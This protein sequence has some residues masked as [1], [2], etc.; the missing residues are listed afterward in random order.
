[1]ITVVINAAIAAIAIPNYTDYVT[2][3]KFAEA[4]GHLADQRVK[5]EQYYMD[6]RRY[7]SD[8]GGATSGPGNT[9]THTNPTSFDYTCATSNANTVGAQ[10]Y[11]I[12]A[13]GKAAE[14][15]QGISFTVNQA[16]T[17]TTTVAGGSAMATKG[18]ATPSP[19]NCWIKKKPSQC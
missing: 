13:T 3:S 7:S 1:M 9:I 2:R 8:T 19:N 14:G 11:T 10:S 18:Y 12:T 17:R 15:L 6:N 16:N 5:M 4:V